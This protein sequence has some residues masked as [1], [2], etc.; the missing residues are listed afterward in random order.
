MSVT[1]VPSR[2]DHVNGRDAFAGNPLPE[3]VIGVPTNPWLG[4]M[5]KVSIV[6]GVW[7]AADFTPVYGRA[8]MSGSPDGATKLIGTTGFVSAAYAGATIEAAKM[9]TA[10]MATPRAPNTF[11][12]I[13][14]FIFFSVSLR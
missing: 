8:G 2:V 5:S 3:M 6:D 14:F 10:I 4:A 7:N 13:I 12:F 11:V 9:A 1:Q